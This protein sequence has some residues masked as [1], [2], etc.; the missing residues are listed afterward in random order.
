MACYYVNSIFSNRLL[1]IVCKRK[2][3]GQTVDDVVVN[4]L[5]GRN[6][7]FEDL[8][9][10]PVY[11]VKLLINKL[12]IVNVDKLTSEE[13]PSYPDEMRVVRAIRILRRLTGCDFLATTTYNFKATEIDEQRKDLL[14]EHENRDRP[15]P[16][17]RTW[18][19][20]DTIFIAPKD[21]QASVIQQWKKWEATQLDH[22]NFPKNVPL[23]NW[24][25]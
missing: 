6:V 8:Q 25:F 12:H 16:F 23:D 13:Q 11:T 18:M 14:I 22:W 9:T 17:F 10:K 15:M 19:S 5:D 3:D 20:S 24:Y 4:I 2:K 7:N 21:V 1:H